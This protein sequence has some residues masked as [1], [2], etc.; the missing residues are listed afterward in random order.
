MPATAASRLGKKVGRCM[1]SPCC[2]MVKD[3]CTAYDGGAGPGAVGRPPHPAAGGGPSGGTGAG[4]RTAG[5]APAGGPPPAPPPPPTAGSPGPE[6]PPLPPHK[7]RR[8]HP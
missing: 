4:R 6:Q 2:S 8:V 3:L 1:V 5:G 7:G